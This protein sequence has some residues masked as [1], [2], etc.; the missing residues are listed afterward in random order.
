MTK[1]FGKVY[2]TPEKLRGHYISIY[3]ASTFKELK[4][5]DKDWK[6]KHNGV[7][8]YNFNNKKKN[9]GYILFDLNCLNRAL[10]VHECT[11]AGNVY[12]QDCV[13]PCAVKKIKDQN[14]LCEYIEECNARLTEHLF[15]QI[16]QKCLDFILKS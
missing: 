10:I 16:E 5:L 1:R 6:R 13:I 7:C 4:A 3:G 8:K 15:V 14:E 2:F 9:K 12:L 11:H